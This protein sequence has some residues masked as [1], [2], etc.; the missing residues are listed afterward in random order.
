MAD[1]E[2]E[3]AEGDKGGKG[4]GRAKLI[5]IIV[6]SVLLAVGLSVG[7]TL[8]FTG[9]LG[10]GQAGNEPPAEEQE[11]AAGPEKAP[12]RYLSL[13]PE[14]IVNFEDQSR[15]SYLQVELE[16]MARSQEPLDVLTRHMPRVRNDILL[17]LSSQRFESISTT[18]GKEAL[19]RQILEHLQKVVEEETG[20]PGVEAVYFTSFIMQ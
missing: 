10:Q 18:A 16:V 20:E 3:L 14:F 1:E 13:D 12:A 8:Y 9:V 19:R 2:L 15:V 7:A 17:L 11:E 6:L 4:G 5:A